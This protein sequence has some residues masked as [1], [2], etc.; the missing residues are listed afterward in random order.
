MG[1]GMGMGAHLGIVRLQFQRRSG[2]KTETKDP[3]VDGDHEISSLSFVTSFLLFRRSVVL[4]SS[5]SSPTAHF[6]D[7]LGI[8]AARGRPSRE[9]WKS[10]TTQ[11]ATVVSCCFLAVGG[12][13]GR[14]AGTATGNGREDSLEMSNS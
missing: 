5:H 8:N 12:G 13:A 11:G 10:A 6:E 7:A 1:M 4:F 9:N 2:G 3:D 14:R